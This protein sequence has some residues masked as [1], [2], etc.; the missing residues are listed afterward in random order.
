[1]IIEYTKKPN[2]QPAVFSL[3]VT[4]VGKKINDVLTETTDNAKTKYVK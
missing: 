1:M 2:V 4:F 3:D